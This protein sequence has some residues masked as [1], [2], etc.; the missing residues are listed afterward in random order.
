MSL[1]YLTPE[2]VAEGRTF[3]RAVQAGDPMLEAEV[4]DRFRLQ[5][6][7]LKYAATL[8]DEAEDNQRLRAVLQRIATWSG[9]E[10]DLTPELRGKSASATKFFTTVEPI[11]L[12]REALAP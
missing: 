5:A 12:A 4:Y 9:R 2:Q 1:N 6:W 8:L 11:R 7:L 3:L 10:D